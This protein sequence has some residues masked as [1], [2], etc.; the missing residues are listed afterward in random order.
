[1][2]EASQAVSTAVVIMRCSYVASFVENGSIQ[3]L[4]VCTQIL[5]ASE[6]FALQRAEFGPEMDSC[7][8]YRILSIFVQL[9][10]KL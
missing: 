4:S 6:E 1:M 9:G 3:V 10:F 8:V 7:Q 2:A 5:K